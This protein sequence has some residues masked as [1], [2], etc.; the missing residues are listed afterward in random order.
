MYVPESFLFLH[1]EYHSTR[2]ILMLTKLSDTEEQKEE[3]RKN[4]E[5]FL[6]YSKL[7]E[8]ELNQRFKFILKGT[9][10]AEGAKAVSC[11]LYMNHPGIETRNLAKPNICSFRQMKCR[12]NLEEIKS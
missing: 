7:I 8:S 4:P 1:L 10:E 2:V 6:K 12:L 3:F 5:K 9:P 11:S